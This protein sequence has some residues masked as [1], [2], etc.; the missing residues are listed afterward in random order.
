VHIG[1][2]VLVVLMLAVAA[3]G[4]RLRRPAP[5]HRRPPS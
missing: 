4:R 2:A 5:R 3:S 1:G